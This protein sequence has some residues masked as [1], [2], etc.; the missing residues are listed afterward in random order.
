MAREK[1][2]E[3]DKV[4]VI[5]QKIPE[6]R[7][8]IAE[9]IF[10]EIEFME[11]TLE[12]LKNQIDAEGTVTLFE[13]GKQRFHREHPALKAYNITIQRY[14]LLYKQLIALLP[15]SESGEKDPLMEFINQ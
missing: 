5:M 10:K 11:R 12:K 6:D 14:S 1:L 4:R 8:P 7:L 13:Q 2:K 3:V 9:S 15:A